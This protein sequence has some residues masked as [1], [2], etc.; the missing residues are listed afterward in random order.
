MTT[1]MIVNTANSTSVQMAIPTIGRELDLGEGELQWL[2]SAYPLSSGCLLLAFG[3][4]ADLYGRKKTFL[5]GSA[6]L[7]ALTLA[8]AFPSDI[9]ILN[10]LRGIQGLGAAAT[11]P[12]AVG[13]LAHRFPPGRARS[14]AYA[15]FSAGA[16]L[17][18][19][20]GSAVG[21]ALTESTAPTWRS[22]FY[23]MSGITFL[24][25]VCGW[26]SI[27]RDNPSPG[28]DKR[29]DWLGAFIVSA[30]LVLV[31]FSLGQGEL[32]P[33]KWRTPYIIA[34]LITGVLLIV[35]FLLWQRYLEKVHDDANAP[36]SV[37]TPPP[38]MKISIWTR[39]HGRLSAMLAIVFL[40]WCSF[41]GWSFWVQMY[42][43]NYVGLTP[44]QTVL[45]V[46]PMT[47]SGL[48]CN[49][50][51]GLFISYIP[52]VYLT[53][54]GT[55][56]TAIACLLLA[57]VNPDVTFWAYGF[58]SAAIVVLGADFVFS[59]GTI[60]VAKVALPDEQSVA[61]GLFNTLGQLGT[62]VGVSVSTVIFNSVTSSRTIGDIPV[63]EGP[64]QNLAS[65]HA[66]QWSNFAFGIIGTVIAVI[67]FRGVGV[68]GDRKRK[69]TSDEETATTTTTGTVPSI[70]EEKKK[71]D[72][73]KA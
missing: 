22:P 3:R 73:N 69:T 24:S 10:T 26:F 14:W 19:I 66:A 49:V 15:T 29:I 54:I 64:G 17:G 43:Q 12:A 44:L 55:G 37:L 70:R 72:Q 11:I 4:V 46:L 40:E 57:L 31:I 25:L 21:G 20:F 63:R 39:D 71:Q 28:V 38:L 65:Y 56:A 5:A 30:G 32:A 48:T 45:R 2:A 42:Y 16:P 1:A 58:T 23:L 13:I 7:A 47:V 61:G 41:F 50:F 18:G 62:A 34:L 6:F 8:C 53:A 52:I 67:C 35:V 36:Y 27:P 60:Y 68:V 9:V 59:A 51:I 33:Q